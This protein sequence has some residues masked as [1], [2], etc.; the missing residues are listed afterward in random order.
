[1]ENP[2]YQALV[3]LQAVADYLAA[4]RG[5]TGVRLS[6]LAREQWLARAKRPGDAD[7]R[8][9]RIEQLQTPVVFGGEHVATLVS[10][11]IEIVEGDEPPRRGVG[12]TGPR[13]TASQFQWWERLLSIFAQHITASANRYL[14]AIQKNDPPWVAHAKEHVKA[15]F[16]DRVTLEDVARHCRMTPD[17]LSNGFKNATGMTF[18][19]Y[20]T[21]VRVEKARELLRNRSLRMDE[22]AWSSG[23]QSVSHFSRTFRYYTGMTPSAFREFH[24]LP[25]TIAGGAGATPSRRSDLQASNQGAN[26]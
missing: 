25:R 5:A 14:A 16:L 9:R 26:G 17:Q 8:A 10:D 18:T 11:P 15:R 1:M 12:P 13:M 21:R 24:A 7:P 4:F 19:E 20:V 2:S 23:F 22:V 3:K 6:F